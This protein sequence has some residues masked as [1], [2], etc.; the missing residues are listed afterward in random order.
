LGDKKKNQTERKV[1]PSDD[2]QQSPRLPTIRR[3]K[4]TPKIPPVAVDSTT[5]NRLVEAARRRNTNRLLDANQ[6]DVQALGKSPPYLL[7][8]PSSFFPKPEQGPNDAFDPPPWLI[9]EL[10]KIMKNPVPTPKLSNIKF[11]VSEQAA[12]MATARSYLGCT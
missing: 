3:Q 10:K 8:K 6:E 9:E 2:N 12:G 7:Q 11:E 5:P 1:A 4:T